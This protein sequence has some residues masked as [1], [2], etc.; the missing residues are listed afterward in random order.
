DGSWSPAPNNRGVTG[1]IVTGLLRNG[2]SPDDEPVAKGLKFIESLVNEKEGHIAGQGANPGLTNY[3]TSINVMALAAAG[4]EAKYKP[5]IK[6]AVA[7]LKKYQWDEG[8]GKTPQDDFYGGAGYGGKNSRPDLSNTAFFLEALK[9]AGLDKTDDAFRKAA[10][11]V[12]KCKNFKS[13]HNPAPWA[14]ANNDGSFIY[15]GANGGENRRTDGEGTKTDFGG[16]GSM[17]YAGIKSLIYAGVG[18]E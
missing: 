12:S 18:K 9:I 7:Y 13:E 4:R 17:T 2:M 6:D 14:A 10:V 5:V 8:E 3:I 15:T 16:Y 1:I 11:F